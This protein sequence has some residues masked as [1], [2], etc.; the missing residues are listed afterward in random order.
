M[1]GKHCSNRVFRVFNLWP[2][3]AMSA[4]SIRKYRQIVYAMFTQNRQV[5][6]VSTGV[7]IPDKYWDFENHRLR[8]TCPDK[9]S[10][11]SCIEST[12]VRLVDAVNELKRNGTEPTPAA[13][14]NI[15][16]PNKEKVLPFFDYFEKYIQTK[17]S[18][19]SPATVQNLR[20]AKDSLKEFSSDCEK[21]IDEERLDKELFAEYIAY[22]IQVKRYAD[23]TI[24]LHVRKIREFFKWAYPKVNID[25]IRYN[26]PP[27][28]EPVFLTQ[29]ELQ[30]LKTAD[31]DGFRT[32]T[33]DLF[34]FCCL[35][36]MRYSDS[37]LFKR[38]WVQDGMISYRMKKTGGKAMVPVREEVLSILSN[39][40]GLSPRLSAQKYNYFLKL[41]F[42]EL[43][44]NRNVTVYKFSAGSMHEQVFPLNQVITS[45][46]ARKT[47]ITQSLLHG[48]P[49]Q[50][51]MKMSGHT[52][53][54]S[55]QPYIAITNQH[56]KEV[57][58]RWEI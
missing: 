35:T 40:D 14:R 43:K 22:E 24:N 25:H 3:L 34:L 54:K 41:L 48:I 38:E 15:F 47:F 8:K 49:I 42:L 52:D 5:F 28:Q 10:K 21:T 11:Q 36:G 1:S 51:V 31:L 17:R 32:K 18:R 29:E 2:E 44:M 19:L 58:K 7:R 53:Y 16:Y 45:H 30:I 46:I 6:K 4:F 12:M 39:Y 23:Y 9:R 56:L 55:M 13:I 37:Q 27:V 50:D 26:L 57:A 33:R 20:R